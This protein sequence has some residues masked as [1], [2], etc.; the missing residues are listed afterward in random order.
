MGNIWKLAFYWHGLS[1]QSAEVAEF[2]KNYQ[3]IYQQL[4]D[5]VL[6]YMRIRPRR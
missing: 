3:K 4:D 2:A 6:R 1:F 5:V